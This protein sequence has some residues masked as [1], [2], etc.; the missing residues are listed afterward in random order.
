MVQWCSALSNTKHFAEEG[1][2]NFVVKVLKPKDFSLEQARD[3]I[4]SIE[5]LEISN[6][7]SNRER[8]EYFNSILD[9]ENTNMISNIHGTPNTRIVL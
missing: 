1:S 3:R 5:L 7:L 9:F 4:S 2:F 6:N 8:K